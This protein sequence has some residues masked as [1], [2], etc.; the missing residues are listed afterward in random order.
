MRRP[1]SSPGA[2]LR[3]ARVVADAVL[4]IL[5][6]EWGEA[7]IAVLRRVRTTNTQQARLSCM[8]SSRRAPHASTWCASAGR[9]SRLWRTQ[10]ACGV[11]RRRTSWRGNSTWKAWVGA[12][13]SRNR[14]SLV[15]AEPVCQHG[16]VR[17]A[18]LAWQALRDATMLAGARSRAVDSPPQT[19]CRARLA[20]PNASPPR[21]TRCL[22]CSVLSY[23]L[24]AA[25]PPGPLG[26]PM[27]TRPTRADEHHPV[28][29]RAPDGHVEC[30]IGL[31]VDAHVHRHR[32]ADPG[33]GRRVTAHE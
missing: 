4:D 9:S 33:D 29:L 32:V 27:R 18:H 16:W 21:R 14:V 6:G 10:Q 3:P 13:A 19:A 31:L 23:N 11:R 12:S 5:G 1:P 30:V 15:M 2:A 25:A 22:R 7:A 24:F 28:A 20:P 17:A 26:R 8:Q